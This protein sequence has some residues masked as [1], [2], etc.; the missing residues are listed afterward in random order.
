MANTNFSQWN[1]GAANQENDSTYQGD[2]QRTGGAVSGPFDS[3]LANKLFYQLTTWMRAMALMM[4]GK[5]YSPQDGTTP[6]AADTSSNAAVTE[7]QSV[8][9]NILTKADILGPSEVAYLNNGGTGQHGFGPLTIF[10][11]TTT[12]LYRL[13]WWAAVTSPDVTAST[14]GPLTLT[15]TWG[16]VTHTI[17]CGA[18]S[19]AGAIETSDAGNTT[20]TVLLGLPIFFNC[21]SGTNIE[22]TL[23]YA[24]TH[25]S[26]VYEFNAKLEY[27]VLN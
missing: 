8:L 6:Y 21:D 27:F 19:N 20:A 7:L 1:P 18:Q 12:G 26:M 3:V 5:G 22:L 9:N 16:G 4:V 2:S 23:G 10:T 17:T 13:S 14:L 25:N 24:S 15:F 11:T